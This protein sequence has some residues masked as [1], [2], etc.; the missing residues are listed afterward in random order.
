MHSLGIMMSITALLTINVMAYT[1]LYRC[2]ETRDSSVV[3]YGLLN[4]LTSTKCSE[5]DVL[6]IPLM[7]FAGLYVVMS[8]VFLSVMACTLGECGNRRQIHNQIAPNY[9]NSNRNVMNQPYNQN[10]MMNY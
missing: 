1:S 10:R 2:D 9:E 4:S 7:V 8:I 6:H 5:P 3:S